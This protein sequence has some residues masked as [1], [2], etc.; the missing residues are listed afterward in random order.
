MKEKVSL[1]ETGASE[2]GVMLIRDAG[3]D[4]LARLKE[5]LP[6][7]LELDFDPEPVL[8]EKLFGPGFGG[9]AS[10]R[11]ALDDDAIRGVAVSCGSAIRMIAVEPG[12]RRQGIGSRL[13]DDAMHAIARSSRYATVGAAAGNYL[14]AGIPEDRN[15][16]ITFFGNRG[17][18]EITRTTDMVA[19]IREALRPD[20]VPRIAVER[21]E[22]FDEPLEEFLVTGFGN[23]IAWEIGHGLLGNRS[24]VRVAR[25]ESAIVGFTACEINNAGLGTFGPQGVTPAA[26]GQGIGTLLLRH[27]L[28]DLREMGHTAARIPWVSSTEYYEKACGAVVAGEYVVMRRDAGAPRKD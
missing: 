20:P 5:F 15:E 17:F 1:E 22:S 11:V 14:V 23:S 2:Y 18:E 24:V 26:R 6:A 21:V 16:V 12:Y 7:A 4:D 25:S 3:R 13:L 28:R 27:S 10:C 8:E 9:P 19:N